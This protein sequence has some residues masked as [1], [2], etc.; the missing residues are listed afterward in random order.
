METFMKADIFFVVTTFVVILVGVGIFVC[1]FYFARFLR[2]LF[3]IS[4]MA[5]QEIFGVTKI[6]K[7]TL[8]KIKRDINN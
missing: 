6:V 2:N 5:K 8:K 7:S 4:E 3:L 1:A